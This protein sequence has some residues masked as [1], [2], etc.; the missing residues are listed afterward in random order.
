M[1]KDMDKIWQEYMEELREERSEKQKKDEETAILYEEL[2]RYVKDHWT[3]PEWQVDEREQ[4][5]LT[6]EFEHETNNK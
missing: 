4:V 2:Y 3:D 6:E 5:R 1:S